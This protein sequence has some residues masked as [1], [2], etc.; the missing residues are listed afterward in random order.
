MDFFSV[1]PYATDSLLLLLIASTPLFRLA[2][3]PPSDSRQR[4][5]N[6]DGLRGF[7]ALGVFFHH[8]ATY[9]DYILTGRWTIP[10]SRFYGNIGPVGVSL[11]FMITGYLFWGKLT[12]SRGRMDWGRL[13]V[14]RAFRIVPLYLVLALVIIVLSLVRSRWQVHVPSFLLCLELIKWLCGG[15]LLGRDIN[16]I[17]TIPI[18]AGV[19]WSLQF[20]WIF[21]LALFP[22]SL[23]ARRTSVALTFPIIVAVLIALS[24]LARPAHF[25]LACMLLFFLGMSAASIRRLVSRDLS[26]YDKSLSATALL[27]LIW[28]LFGFDYVYKVVPLLLLGSAFCL[29]VLEAT[30]FGVLV[31]R[32]ARRLGDVSY[33]IY[34]LQ[35]PVLFLTFGTDVLR[36]L[37]LES[38]L[39]HW[40]IALLAACL[41]V[42]VATL[43]HWLIERP[44]IRLGN[45]ISSRRQGVRRRRA[46][47]S[48]WPDARHNALR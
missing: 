44:G 47:P 2:D 3:S 22:M 13:Y 4:D 10:P 26:S 9:H 40:A 28:V 24:L 8:A 23:A 37:A 30:M 32:A 14:A 36:S 39:Y 18:S 5:R 11:F 19:T 43:A 35:G 46:D 41:L 7:L 31:S 38:A 42:S 27:C 17:D 1:I 20:E 34:L 16:G 33:G 6:I 45:N 21:Y 29:I 48:Q 25:S 12:S 15:V